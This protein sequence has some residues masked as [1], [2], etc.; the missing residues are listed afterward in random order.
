M[1]R[2]RCE[3]CGRF[4][5][6][7]V[8]RRD[9]PSGNMRVCLRDGTSIVRDQHS[10]QLYEAF[11]KDWQGIPWRTVSTTKPRRAFN[12]N[13]PAGLER[14]T[15]PIILRDKSGAQCMRRAVIDGLCRQHAPRTGYSSTQAAD[16]MPESDFYGEG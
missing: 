8:V 11:D 13:P 9:A 12:A 10:E 15:A 16:E 6:F 14:C 3:V 2:P 5:R 1:A 4:A 7:V